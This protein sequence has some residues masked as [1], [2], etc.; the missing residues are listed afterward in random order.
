M[1]TNASS[2]SSKSYHQPK[3]VTDLTERNVTTIAQLEEAAKEQRTRA[4]RLAEHIADFCGSI[5]FVWVHIVWFGGWV[6]V[7][8]LPGLPH[9]DTFPFTFLTLVVSL[10]AIFLSTFILISQNHQ[11]RLSEKRN[12]LDLQIN[13]LAEQENT[14]ILRLLDR[15]ADKV[16]VVIDDDPDIAVLEEATE[17]DTLEKQIDEAITVTETT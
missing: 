1:D 13:L 4:D 11:T 7:N 14:K 2:M 9:F 16:G 15:I 10:E 12:H 8:L 6:L 3:T 5:A 17:P